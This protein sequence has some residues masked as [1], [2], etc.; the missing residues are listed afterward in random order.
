M[1]KQVQ[2]PPK[3]QYINIPVLESDNRIFL[4]KPPSF[5]NYQQPCLLHTAVLS[6]LGALQGSRIH[7]DIVLNKSPRHRRNFSPTCL[8]TNWTRLWDYRLYA[9]QLSQNIFSLSLRWKNQSFHILHSVLVS[10][11]VPDTSFLCFPV[12]IL[13]ELAIFS[14][15]GGEK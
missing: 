14:G 2:A 10:L 15:E 6:G 3:N 7:F 4:S 1:E 13:A 11:Q 9:L 12:Q 8:V 5:I